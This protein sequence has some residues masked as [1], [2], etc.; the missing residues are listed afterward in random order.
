[1]I[2]SAMKISGNLKRIGDYAKEMAVQ[3]VYM[4]TG[5]HSDEAR[6]KADETSVNAQV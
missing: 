1:M 2:L 5:T 6:P 4:V 3:A